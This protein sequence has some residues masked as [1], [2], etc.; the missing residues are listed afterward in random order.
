MRLIAKLGQISGQPAPSVG[1]VVHQE[2]SLGGDLCHD[3]RNVCPSTQLRPAFARRGMGRCTSVNAWASREREPTAPAPSKGIALVGAAHTR[4]RSRRTAAPAL[5]PRPPPQP[6]KC[7]WSR[8]SNMS[9]AAQDREVGEQRRRLPVSV[10]TAFRQDLGA[11]RAR[12]RPAQLGRRT[13]VTLSGR[14]SGSVSPMRM[15]RYDA[16]RG[17]TRSPRERAR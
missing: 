8:P 15:Q 10:S 14:G 13:T 5:D 11:R 9:V 2:D 7:G 1:I 16:E 12:H 4:P 17:P 6:R 3:Y